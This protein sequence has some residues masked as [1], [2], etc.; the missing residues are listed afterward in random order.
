MV[1]YKYLLPQF[2]FYDRTGI[3]RLLEAQAEMGW[4][5]DKISTIG[6]RLRRIEPQKVH[7]AV[8]YFP[9]AS[10]Y[11]PHPSE[12][13]QELHEF[14]AHSG[15][16]LAG[17][18]AQMQV[19]YNL[20]P[21]PVPIETDPLLELEN[22]HRSA[23]R[24]YLPAYFMLF[25]LAVMQ[26]ALQVG[27]LLSFPLTYLSQDTT[28][29]NWLCELVLLGMCT[30]EICGYF[31]WYRRAKPA[32]E[33][34]EFIETRG[35]R[36]V[37][38]S[39]LGVVLIALGCLLISMQPR[40][41]V[42][43][44]VV[45]ALM[46]FVLLTVWGTHSVMKKKGVSRNTNR[47]VTWVLS[48]VLAM[49][50]CGLSATVLSEVFALPVWDNG[51]VVDQ[52]EWNGLKFD[53]YKDEIPLRVEDLTDVKSPDYSY[54]AREQDSVFLKR[55][56]YSQRIWGRSDLPELSYIVYSTHIPAIYDLCVREA[57]KPADY[58]MGAD[59]YGNLYYE[60]YI[61]QEAAPWG[62]KDV[63][64]RYAN[65][66]PYDHYVLCYEDCVVILQSD[67]ELTLEQMSI[68]GEKLDN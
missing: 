67:W 44:I 19:L 46:A 29:F 16:I 34:G 63:Y 40:M 45:L 2:T 27:Q 9:K 51:K 48:I 1:K 59:I 39:L 3:C 8:T 15:W 64:R 53:I 35:F 43:M 11:D 58:P 20:S 33:N 50:V 14:C 7:Y 37:Q 31:S 65:G 25:I 5:L 60:T 26:I 68:V 36:K 6:W 22:I 57:T 41:T 62:A 28:L 61:Y 21:N 54:E 10:A 18:T 52:Y 12:V 38:L 56:E 24:N 47:L 23:K 13:Q 32:A 4:L 55:G 17:T 49:A 66:E 30:M 42:M